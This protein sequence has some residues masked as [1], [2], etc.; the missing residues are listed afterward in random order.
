MPDLSSVQASCVH[1]LSH[2]IPD[3]PTT[4]S[5][6]LPP[7]S[8]NDSQLA[9]ALMELLE[10]SY[11]LEALHPGRTASSPNLAIESAEPGEDHLSRLSEQ[12]ETL[13]TLVQTRQE[14]SQADRNGDRLHATIGLVREELAWARVDALSHAVLEL[15]S[16]RRR[17]GK[18]VNGQASGQDMEEQPPAYWQDAT[19]LPS[20]LAESSTSSAKEYLD[21]ERPSIS[22]VRDNGSGTREK[23]LAELDDVTS[24][25]ERLQASSSRF[26]DQRSEPRA[27]KP[28]AE[29]RARAERDK[30]RELDEIFRLIERSHARRRDG[31]RVDV[32]ELEARRL[33]R[34]RRCLEVLLDQ[35]EDGRLT[36]QDADESTEKGVNPD[37]ARA[38]E[39]RDVSVCPGVQL[40]VARSLPARPGGQV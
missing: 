15:V 25:I 13:Q 24:A 1:A 16:E 35:G 34:R 3:S 2:L 22:S 20:Y 26:D 31:T 28:T 5:T 19:D 17:D 40:T 12:M 29:V 14:S 9:Q 21:K 11:A 33:A 39:L 37:L 8:F 27:A 36:G 18:Q 32:E 6:P 38:R 23:E 10:V 4:S 7:L 30:M